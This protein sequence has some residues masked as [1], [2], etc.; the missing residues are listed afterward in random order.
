MPAVSLR[1]HSIAFLLL[2]GACSTPPAVSTVKGYRAFAVGYHG[3]V[4]ALGAAEQFP[5]PTITTSTK[6][7]ARLVTVRTTIVEMPIAIAEKFMP[8]L[9]EKNASEPL[10]EPSKAPATTPP[11][12]D[13]GNPNAAGGNPGRLQPRKVDVPLQ[14]FGQVPASPPGKGPGALATMRGV[15]ADPAELKKSLSQ[16]FANGQAR[17]LGEPEISCAEGAEAAVSCLDQT[18]LVQRVDLVPSGNSEFAFDFAVDSVQHGTWLQL[19]PRRA[20]N[21]GMQL[22]IRLQLRE[23]I[24]PVPVAET[25]FGRIHVPA[26]AIQD[27]RAIEPI[28]PNDG[29]VLGT[30]SGGS[31]GMV[32][33]ALVFIQAVPGGKGTWVLP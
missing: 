30:M 32:V 6:E 24:Q 26:V 7:D 9:L 8:A 14:G 28:A 29:L 21:G 10:T 31:P 23:L 3:E 18:A 20:A 1:R 11:V 16:L 4:V 33:L 19:S 25:R 13:G 2:A 27:L 22:G 17:L 15:H 5:E 12:T